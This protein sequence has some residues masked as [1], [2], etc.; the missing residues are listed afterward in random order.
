MFDV[1]CDNAL[2]IAEQLTF[3]DSLLFKQ[4]KIYQCLVKKIF[5]ILI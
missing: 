3:W 5:L 1:A 2:Q 4:L